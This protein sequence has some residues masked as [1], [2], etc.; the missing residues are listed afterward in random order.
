MDNTFY[1]KRDSKKSVKMS[2]NIKNKLHSGDILTFFGNL[3][4]DKSYI[5]KV[6]SSKI[7][8]KIL[9]VSSKGVL[10]KTTNKYIFSGEN[11]IT[12]QGRIFSKN[13]K[14]ENSILKSYTVKN[15]SLALL[16]GTKKYEYSYG[17]CE[18]IINDNGLSSV[19]IMVGII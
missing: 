9:D 10:I 7:T 1:Y 14:I 12:F 17:N 19:K 4:S 5:K 8:Y 18:Y 6:A 3:Y 11:S 2:R 15:S 16:K 13:L